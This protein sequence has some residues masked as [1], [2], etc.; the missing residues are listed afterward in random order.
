MAPTRPRECPLGLQAWAPSL[1]GAEAADR[2]HRRPVP[3]PGPT[4]QCPPCQVP[5]PL[6]ITQ[7][8]GVHAPPA[9][10][11]AH[12]GPQSLGATVPR[13]F[14]LAPQGPALLYPPHPPRLSQALPRHPKQ[15]PRKLGVTGKAARPCH[16]RMKGHWAPGLEEGPLGGPLRR[17]TTSSLV[18]PQPLCGFSEGNRAGPPS[19]CCCR[20]GV[21]GW[22]SSPISPCRKRSA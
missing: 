15:G 7:H 12:S 13:T 11:S 10:H 16:P 9:N 8:P 3:L 14:T 17:E 19:L 4:P 2:P 22:E 20:R 1:W 6:P 18:T 21:P 5:G